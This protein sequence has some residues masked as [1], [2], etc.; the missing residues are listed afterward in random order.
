MARQRARSGKAAMLGLLLLALA[1][2][3]LLV[4]LAVRPKAEI[5]G[6]TNAQRVEYIESFGWDAG[7][8]PTD[9]REITIPARFDDAYNQYN[10]LQKEQGFDLRKYCACDAHKY[11]YRIRNYDGADPA[12]PINANLIVIDGKIV[13]ADI[14][15][16]EANGFVTVLAKK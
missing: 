8:V 3:W 6:A 13:A 9:I 11:T 7:T 12:V 4:R 2:I 16:A 5:A 14:S 10:A 15:S 1:G